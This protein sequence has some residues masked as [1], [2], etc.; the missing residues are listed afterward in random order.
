MTTHPMHL[1]DL[2]PKE[3]AAKTARPV[4]LSPVTQNDVFLNALLETPT[5]KTLRRSPLEWAA[6]TGFARRDCRDADHRTVVHNGDDPTGEVRRH[7]P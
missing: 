1:F 4:R 6:A 7:F 5:T 3:P 2:A